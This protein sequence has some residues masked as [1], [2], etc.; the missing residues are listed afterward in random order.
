MKA[1]YIFAALFALCTL[2]LFA[3]D[4]DEPPR[5]FRFYFG[6]G[7]SPN[8]MTPVSTFYCRPDTS[9]MFII[10]R[11]QESSP[12]NYRD[13]MPCVF[14][15]WVPQQVF[16]FNPRK[17]RQRMTF[18]AKLKNFGGT[19]GSNCVYRIGVSAGISMNLLHPKVIVAPTLIVGKY[20][21]FHAGVCFMQKP[22][23]RGEFSEGERVNTFLDS[24]AL[25]E[26]LYYSE[27]FFGVAFRLDKRILPDE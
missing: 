4:D 24:G 15:T 3:Q 13:A 20:L 6:W 11:Q 12:W 1:K 21:T 18:G 19:L 9:G 22:T 14:Y 10:S 17:K 7:F 8:R 23:L 2:S 25:H 27:W 26:N 16:A 5:N